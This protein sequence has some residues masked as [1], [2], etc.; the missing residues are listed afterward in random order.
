MSSIG[1]SVLPPACCVFCCSESALGAYRRV[2][3][4]L[5]CTS[6]AVALLSLCTPTHSGGEMRGDFEAT[7]KRVFCSNMQ[8]VFFWVFGSWMCR[9]SA[10]TGSDLCKRKVCPDRIKNHDQNQNFRHRS[11]S[12]VN[13]SSAE[14]F[15]VEG[16]LS[17]LSVRLLKVSLLM[18]AVSFCFLILVFVCFHTCFPFH[19]C[20]LS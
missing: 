18:S 17:F 19:P 12:H 14:W 10:E 9:K 11:E 20:S 7:K 2:G 5:Y 1:T 8:S 16:E 4:Y 13:R 6:T 15:P 3:C